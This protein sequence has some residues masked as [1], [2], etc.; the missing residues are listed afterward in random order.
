MKIS[1][2]ALNLSKISYIN[3]QIN[4]SMQLP[5]LLT[6]IMETARDLVKAVGT[7]LL[8]SD[9]ETGDLAFHTVRGEMRE[10]IKGN[11]VPR[12][13]GIAGI[14]AQTG[15]PLIINDAQNDPRFF[16]E[17]DSKSSFVTQNILCVPMI[18]R[19]KLVGVIEAVNATGRGG[20]DRQDQRLIQY[21]ADQ[22]AIAVTNRRLLDDL[23]SRIEELTALYEISQSISRSAAE[24]DVFNGIID[25]IARSL[26]VERCSLLILDAP[27]ERLCVKACRGLPEELSPGMEVS[28]ENTVA[29]RVVRT[30]EPFMSGDANRGLSAIPA[31]NSHSYATPSFVSVPVRSGDEILGV[32]SISDRKDGGPFDSI[33]LRVLSTIASQVAEAQ[34]HILY[35]R[36]LEA[37]RRLAQEIEIA[38]EIQRK[39]L[40]RIPSLFGSHELK[41]FNRPA[42]EVGGDFYDFFPFEDGRYAVLVGDV[43]GKGIPAALFMGSTRSIIRAEMRVNERPCALLASSNRYIFENSESG[44]FVTLFYALIDT[45]KSSIL[46]GCAGHNRQLLIR[47]SPSRVE[48]LN[49]RGTAL[50]IAGGSG[51]EERTLDYRPGDVLV[52]FTDGVLEHLGDMDID[53]GERELARIFSAHLDRGP[54]HVISLLE[55]RL[56]NNAV[57]S[58]FIDDFTI[59][60]IKF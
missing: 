60:S 47:R 18:V 44:M 5:E 57:D 56:S 12:G 39:I 40:P 34:Q 45:A 1:D 42:K 2:K 33:H 20:F 19:E 21:L 10:L 32:L 43:S 25:S 50:G 29:G 59:L 46:Y 24:A 48:T 6:V 9:Q 26:G 23:T 11:K 7:S 17:I 54:S 51:Y 55:E 3:R 52:L 27:R 16:N 31:D 4:S 28:L 53:A 22:A 35:Q 36:T 13:K 41:A 15:K 58:E 8:L 37:Q 38:A 49:A 14:V 30:G